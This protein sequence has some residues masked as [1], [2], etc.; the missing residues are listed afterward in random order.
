[1]RSYDVF[2]T[3]I[4]RKCIWPHGIYS[5]VEQRLGKPG[6][7]AARV[8]A[9]RTLQGREHTLDDIY[10]ELAARGLPSDMLT[11]A[12]T[13]ELEAELENVIPISAHLNQV[14]D[15]DLLVSD[16]YLPAEFIRLLLRRAGLARQVVLLRSAEGKASG[17]VWEA[18]RD[19]GLA[20]RHVGDHPRSDVEMAVRHGASA[21][22]SNV[23][24]P[25]SIEQWLIGQ[26]YTGTALVARALRLMQTSWADPVL[27]ELG[28]L[29]AQVNVPILL[30]TA[31]YLRQ[32]VA[33]LDVDR[34]LFCS[35][36]CRHLERLYRLLTAGDPCRV[37]S[38]YFYT[39][40]LARVRS[41]PA[42]RDYFRKMAT[43]RSL[44]VD[45]CGTGLSLA[46]L[47]RDSGI[48]PRTFLLYGMG[49]GHAVARRYRDGFA[50][51]LEV[52]AESLLNE[53]QG[54][55]NLAIELLNV[56]RHG[57]VEDV[58]PLAGFDASVPLLAASEYGPT[59]S[60]WI[61]TMDAVVDQAAGLLED[62]FLMLQLHEGDAR[63]P[64]EAARRTMVPLWQLADRSAALSSAFGTAHLR[65]NARILDA[66]S[67][68]PG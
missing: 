9:E 54:I 21:T 31:L 58:V 20:V 59:E 33:Q 8:E 19:A 49:P 5:L 29:Q 57:M 55:G 53:E 28:D 62:T 37:E 2:D 64:A 32:R 45:L 65:D 40:R 7:A 24:Q 41:S 42:Y 4:A 39:S 44:V 30:I 15:G 46:R 14:D 56:A 10:T 34:I 12:R 47:Y 38:T 51:G 27:Q 61:A 25:S 16:T 60:A 23:A 1:M 50:R 6:F 52:D 11:R 26:G 68:T 63:C 3:L 17:R 67:A 13:L 66:L 36:D 48:A 18:L 43:P 22:I 35:R